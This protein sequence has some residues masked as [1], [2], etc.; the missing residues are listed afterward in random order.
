M[1]KV[2]IEGTDG[3]GKTTGLKYFIEQAQKRGITIMETREV[4]NPHIQSCVKMR[5]FV[6]DPA[7]KLSGEAMELLFCAMRFE[8]Q[9]W[10]DSLKSK[11]QTP[12]ILISDRGWFSHLAYTDHNVSA[13]FT[14]DVYLK[15]MQQETTKPDIVIYFSVNTDTALARRV[16]RGGDMD[17]IELKG[18]EYQEQVRGSFV[19]YLN[20]HTAKGGAVFTIDA[21]DT[22]EG[23]RAQLDSILNVMEGLAKNQD[24]AVS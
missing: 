8:N 3:A 14:E 18:V 1:L 16:K 19:K 12:N 5:E 11:G 23:V 6:L 17:A 22:I 4:G 21:N 13:K 7:N 10:M 9:K 15:F 20:E 24:Q 2:E